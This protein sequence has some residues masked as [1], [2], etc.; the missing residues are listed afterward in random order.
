MH[1][2]RM[3]ATTGLTTRSRHSTTHLVHSVSG[4]S[5]RVRDDETGT[6]VWPDHQE[7]AP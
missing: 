1:V 6:P 3:S 2:H 5:V 4:R 7:A